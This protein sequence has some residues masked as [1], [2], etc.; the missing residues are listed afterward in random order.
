MRGVVENLRA[1]VR[2]GD[3]MERRRITRMR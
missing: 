2:L 1:A 3:A